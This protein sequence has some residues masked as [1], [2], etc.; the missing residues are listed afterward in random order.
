MVLIMDLQVFY[1]HCKE[2]ETLQQVIYEDNVKKI[3]LCNCY[4]YIEILYK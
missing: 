2:D 1:T 3:I 4:D